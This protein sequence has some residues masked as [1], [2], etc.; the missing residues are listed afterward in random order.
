MSKAA[1]ASMRREADRLFPR[2]TGGILLG[3]RADGQT[4]V[5][6]IIGPG[7]K[8]D[9]QVDGFRPDYDFQEAEIARRYAASQRRE[10]YLGD[11]H[12]HPGADDAQMSFK[13]R[14]TLSRI[15]R[16]GP[17]R[18]PEPLMAIL[19]GEPGGWR[20]GLWICAEARWRCWPLRAVRPAELRKY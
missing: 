15:A 5:T 6:A 4:V 12:S 9:H 2:E 18:A 13:D 1:F 11:W 14:I 20:C 3:Y 10:T 7:P 8:A 16:F 17:A 19:F